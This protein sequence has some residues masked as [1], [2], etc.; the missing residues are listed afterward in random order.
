[1]IYK[2]ENEGGFNE[3]LKDNYFVGRIGLDW[4]L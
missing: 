4:R 3:N 2:T 1:M